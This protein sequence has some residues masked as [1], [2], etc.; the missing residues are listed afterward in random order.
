M[1]AAPGVTAPII[2][3]TKLKHLDEAIKALDLELTAEEIAAVQA[4]YQP[5]QLFGHEQPKAALLLKQK[6]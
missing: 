3:T 1:L 2:G 4:P 6:R 5:H